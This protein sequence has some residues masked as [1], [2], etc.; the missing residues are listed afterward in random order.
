MDS[1][2]ANS[3]KDQLSVIKNMLFVFNTDG[4]YTVMNTANPAKTDSMETGKYTVNGSKGLIFKSDKDAG[5]SK[6]IKAYFKNEYLIL[7]APGQGDGLTIF[8]LKKTK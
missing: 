4:A 8:E 6:K 7:H 5:K 3:I 1:S 2:G